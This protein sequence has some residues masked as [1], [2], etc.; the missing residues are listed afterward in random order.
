MGYDPKP[1]FDS[2]SLEKAPK[3]TLEMIKK[4]INPTTK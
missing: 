4:S 3:E 2:G 1:P